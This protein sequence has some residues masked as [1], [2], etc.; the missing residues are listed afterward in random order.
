[1]PAKSPLVPSLDP[2]AVV[3][4]ALRAFREATGLA[5]C[6]KMLKKNRVGGAVEALASRHGLHETAFCREVKRKWNDRCKDCDLRAVPVRCERART[7]FSHVC[8]AGANEVII[9]LF[10][11]ET[12]A[13]VVYVGQFRRDAS[14][15]AELPLL[16]A[17][18]ETRL[19]GLARLLGAYLGE[20]LQTPRY[21]SESSQGYR[22]EVIHR[23]LERNLRTR[24]TLADLAAHLGL[25][26]T[27]TAHAVREATG[28]SFVEL[29]DSLRMERARSLLRTTYHKVGHVAAECGFSSTH[30]F[31]RFFR[32]QTKMTP[33]AFRRRRRADA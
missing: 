17:E 16:S 2:P 18:D 7:L 30:Y 24:P 20:K 33:L 8:H 26:K 21:V 15:P 3:D 12:L 1:M 25:S 11:D 22:S 6:I 10:V 9:P 31:H 32:G 13:A 23:F 14:Q 28:L 5:V 4:Q 29:R 19:L 27:R